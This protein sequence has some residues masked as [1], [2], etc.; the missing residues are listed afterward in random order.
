[1]RI[2]NNNGVITIVTGIN[3]ADLKEPQKVYDKKGNEVYSIRKANKGE[4]GS[5]GKHGAVLNG[6]VDGKAAYIMVKPEDFDYAKYKESMARNI[7]VFYSAEQVV[8]EGLQ[9][10]NARVERMWSE[11]EG[12]ATPTSAVYYG[13]CEPEVDEDDCTDMLCA[14]AEGLDAIDTEE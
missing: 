10:Y 9:I 8:I 4:A 1:M 5:I 13:T 6:D 3:V 2:I 11:L 12:T 7:E 14:A